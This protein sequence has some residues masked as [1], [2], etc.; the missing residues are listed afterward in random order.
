MHIIAIL[1][2]TEN[3]WVHYFDKLLDI[4]LQNGW[5]IVIAIMFLIMRNY[6]LDIL[7][8][9]EKKIVESTKLGLGKGGLI[10][11][12]DVTHAPVPPPDSGED[13]E[14]FNNLILENNHARRI[15]STLWFHQNEHF[16]ELDQRWTFGFTGRGPD[17][18]DFF[19][20]KHQLHWLGYITTTDDSQ[21]GLT[22]MGIKFCK[23]Y[24]TEIGDYSYFYDKTVTD[25]EDRR[26]L[27]K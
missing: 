24:A 25:P 11:E 16:P 5:P 26:E 27:F 10:V 2:A 14:I 6:I 3:L 13:T 17:Y 4:I 8:T 23:K 22:D 18:H 12:G 1:V 15:L 20:A 19:R 9:I 21:M 7:K